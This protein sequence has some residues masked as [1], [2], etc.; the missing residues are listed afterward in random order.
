MEI[1]NEKKKWAVFSL[2]VSQL[3]EQQENFQVYKAFCF[4]KVFSI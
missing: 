2:Q 1:L 3:A 4:L